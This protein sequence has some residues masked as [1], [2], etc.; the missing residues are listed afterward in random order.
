MVKIIC[1]EDEITPDL[2]ARLVDILNTGGVI[3]VPTDTVYGLITK[4]FHKDA[5]KRL[6]A[7]KGNRVFPY[8]VVLSPLQRL[9][10][11]FDNLNPFQR[12]VTEALLPGPVTLIIDSNPKIPSGFKYA[13]LGIGIRVT[14]HKM[15]NLLMDTLESPLWATSANRSNLVA[16][17]SFSEIDSDLFEMTDMALDGGDTAFGQPSTIIDLRKMPFKVTRTGSWLDKIRRVL[18]EAQSPLNILIVCTGNICR[19][20][21]AEAILKNCFADPERSG[22]SI[23]S[24]GISTVDGLPATDKM[25]EIAGEWGIDYTSH[26]A[27]Q[28]TDKILLNSDLILTMEPYQ[29]EWIID[30]IPEIANRV[31]PVAEPLHQE[32]IPDP[33]GED[34]AIYKKSAETIRSATIGWKTRIERM[35]EEIGWQP[36]IID[37]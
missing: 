2:L 10:E 12:R 13:N 20:P 33:Y 7:I 17:V 29:S 25:I 30:R 37:S 19:S 28:V 36:V 18:I 5:F 11:L 1:V 26:Q 32:T 35:I 16:P 22:V 34:L 8:A 4:A 24:A 31:K 14:A 6:E 15:L 9:E 23:S 3:I 21:L 27:R